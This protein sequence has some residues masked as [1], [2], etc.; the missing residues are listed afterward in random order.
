MGG[1]TPHHNGGEF[2]GSISTNWNAQSQSLVNALTRRLYLGL[3]YVFFLHVHQEY[4]YVVPT[5]PFFVCVRCGQLT[6]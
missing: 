1:G 2:R 6:N 3:M 5:R 4:A